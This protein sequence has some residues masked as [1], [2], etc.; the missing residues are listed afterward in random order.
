M[1]DKFALGWFLGRNREQFGVSRFPHLRV[2]RVLGLYEISSASLITGG[3][4]SAIYGLRYY[5][6]G[7]IF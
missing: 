2:I 3:P 1:I 7:N 5:Y 4:Y 6:F